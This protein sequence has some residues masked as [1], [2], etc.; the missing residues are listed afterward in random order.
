MKRRTLNTKF[1]KT[2][3][4]VVREKYVALNSFIKKIKKFAYVYGNVTYNSQD[5]ET[6]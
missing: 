1:Y 2:F 6:T 5:M 4:T 3:K